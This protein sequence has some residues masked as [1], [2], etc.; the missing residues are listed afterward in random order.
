MKHNNEQTT[1]S[2]TFISYAKQ[3]LLMFFLFSLHQHQHKPH[4]PLNTLNY[5]LIKLLHV[6]EFICKQ[7]NINK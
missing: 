3:E 7:R 1:F 2:A 6:S 4:P 5:W